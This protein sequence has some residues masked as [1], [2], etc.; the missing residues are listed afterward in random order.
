M[1]QGL[2]VINYKKPTTKRKGIHSKSKTSQ[3]KASKNY[4][5]KYKGQGKR[6]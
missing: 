2:K 1:A 4:K 6:S 3:L 5:K